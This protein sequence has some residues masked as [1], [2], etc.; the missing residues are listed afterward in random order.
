MPARRPPAYD[1]PRPTARDRGY[2]AVT[3]TVLID[4]PRDAVHRWN[5]AQ[6]LQDLVEPAPGVPVITGTVPLRGDWDPGGDRT[7]H[8]RRVEF[9]DGNHLAEEVLTDTPDRFRYMIWGFTGPQRFVIAHGIAGFTFASEADRTRV[10]WTYTMLPTS[11][12]L[13]LPVSLFLHRAMGPMMTG[14]LDAMRRG[15]RDTT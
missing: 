2:L 9:S 10:T 8:R 3:R 7:G 14:T 11:P 5:A 4:A 13:R 15:V 1:G 6:D 12:L